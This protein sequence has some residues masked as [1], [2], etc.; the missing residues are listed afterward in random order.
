MLPLG[1]LSARQ[2]GSLLGVSEHTVRRWSYEGRIPLG[3]RM[4]PTA[5]LMWDRSVVDA[6]IAKW[7]DTGHLVDHLPTSADP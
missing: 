1:Y 5:P 6:V 3:E 4:N 7:R 2:V